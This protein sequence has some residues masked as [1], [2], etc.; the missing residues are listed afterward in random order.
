MNRSFSIVLL[1]TFS[2]ILGSCASLSPAYRLGTV[3]TVSGRELQV[4]AG[5]KD[6]S[7]VAGQQVQLVRRVRA[8]NPKSPPSYRERRVGTAQIGAPASEY[9]VE[10]KLLTGS[11][12]RDDQA[13]PELGDAQPR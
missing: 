4:C 11:A 3:S 10:A 1:V 9:C 6:T 13:Y 7:P 2:S 8:G 12:R 5:P